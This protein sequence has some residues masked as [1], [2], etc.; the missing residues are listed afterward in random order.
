MVFQEDEI[1]KAKQL[2]QSK[3][4]C[5]K[6]FYYMIIYI[7]TGGVVYSHDNLRMYTL[8]L[9]TDRDHRS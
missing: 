4:G 5:Y 6:S 9:S 2:D 7:C 3:K 1:F 8:T